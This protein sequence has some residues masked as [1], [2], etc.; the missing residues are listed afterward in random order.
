MQKDARHILG[1]NHIFVSKLGIGNKATTAIVSNNELLPID[2]YVENA[3]AMSRQQFCQIGCKQRSLTSC[4]RKVGFLK[5]LNRKYMALQISSYHRTKQLTQQQHKNSVSSF[6]STTNTLRGDYLKKNKCEFSRSQAAS[7]VCKNFET[8]SLF[9]SG[10][11]LFIK[12]C[13]KF[14]GGCSSHYCDV[15]H[16]L[17]VKHHIFLMQDIECCQCDAARTALF[18]INGINNTID[19]YTKFGK[20]RFPLRRRIEIH[21]K[22]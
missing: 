13:L 17:N 5:L 9:S 11:Q 2:L 8:L 22:L 1:M 10:R 7:E 16:C 14:I 15:L 18:L 19:L 12:W 21:L 20:A 4:A 6:G 3:F